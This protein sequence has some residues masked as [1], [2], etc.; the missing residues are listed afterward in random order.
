MFVCY[1]NYI[2]IAPA[3]RKHLEHEIIR[4]AQRKKSFYNFE[5]ETLY[6]LGGANGL[7]FSPWLTSKLEDFKKEKEI[8]MTPNM[9]I[10]IENITKKEKKSFYN[11][12]RM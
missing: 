6:R 5:A 3:V 10:F 11:Y 2:S 7:R 12:L 8:E 1:R 4:I 9:Q